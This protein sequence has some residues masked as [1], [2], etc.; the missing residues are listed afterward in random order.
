MKKADKVFS[1]FYNTSVNI[2]RIKRGSSYSEEAQTEFV[3]SVL[4]DI[5]PKD[6][7]VDEMDYGL[8]VKRMLTM[9]C[10]NCDISECDY[11]EVD[12]AMYRIVSVKRWNMG[13]EATLDWSGETGG[14]MYG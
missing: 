7:G 9:Y 1:R 6:G 8:S 2:Y 11:A 5:Q 12:G 14:Q 3:R 10:E 13:I 4:A